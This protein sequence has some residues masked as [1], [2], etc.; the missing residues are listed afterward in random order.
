MQLLSG[1][2]EALTVAAARDGGL[3]PKQAAQSEAERAELA[4]QLESVKTR[5]G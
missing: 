2:R 1:L 3:G 4:A 5:C